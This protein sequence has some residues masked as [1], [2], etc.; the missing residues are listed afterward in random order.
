MF[1]AQILINNVTLSNLVQI[2]RY[3]LL[4]GVVVADPH[5]R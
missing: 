4:R 3:V 5:H 1:R 2:A